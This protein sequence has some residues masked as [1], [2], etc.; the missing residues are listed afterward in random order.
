MRHFTLI[1][2]AFFSLATCGCNRN[3]PS[4]AQ[5]PKGMIGKSKLDPHWIYISRDIH[6][7]APPKEIVKDVGLYYVGSGSLLVLYPSGELAVVAC[8]FRK[9]PENPQLSLNGT[10]SF[11]VATGTWSRNADGTLTTI[12]KFCVAPMGSDQNNTAPVE[13]RYVVAQ[14]ASDRIAGLLISP[15]ESMVPLPNNFR[16]VDGIQYMFGF[17]SKCG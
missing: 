2:I 14:Q 3:A 11:T 7:D 6:W 4:N 15:R 16:D 10:V 9:V 13:T 17:A 12:S 5:P 1:V 8:D